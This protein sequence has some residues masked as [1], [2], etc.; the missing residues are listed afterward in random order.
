MFF[1]VSK[2]KTW[3]VIYQMMPAHQK[4][5]IAYRVWEN[6]QS[7]WHMATGESCMTICVSTCLYQNFTSFPLRWLLIHRAIYAKHRMHT[8]FPHSH[9]M[10]NWPVNNSQLS[11]AA[12]SPCISVCTDVFHTPSRL[13]PEH[14]SETIEATTQEDVAPMLMDCVPACLHLG[15]FFPAQ[16]IYK[17]A[18]CGMLLQGCRSKREN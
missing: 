18:F 3:Q 4:I 1:S 17:R 10:P 11:S 12:Y 15:I 7:S 6:V 13:S 9:L 5:K 8:Y 14:R 16:V 2:Q